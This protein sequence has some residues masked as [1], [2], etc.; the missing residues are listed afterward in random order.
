ME[1]N[2]L[3]KNN[4]VDMQSFDKL[5]N[6]FYN[7]EYTCAICNKTIKSRNKDKH[8]KSKSHITKNKNL[9]II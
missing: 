8:E 2:K 1:I 4:K 3:I 5:I 9:N 7:E 6:M